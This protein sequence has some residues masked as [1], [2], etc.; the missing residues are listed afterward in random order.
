MQVQEKV[1]ERETEGEKKGF[2][3][4]WDGWKKYKTKRTMIVKETNLLALSDVQQKLASLLQ[5]Y[6]NMQ[7]QSRIQCMP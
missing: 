1:R 3:A 7:Y 4:R 2:L 5:L 6:Y